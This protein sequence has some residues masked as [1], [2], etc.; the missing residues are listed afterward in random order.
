MTDK[1]LLPCPFCGGGETII[2]ENKGVWGGANSSSEPISVEVKHWCEEFEGMKSRLLSFV[3][4][5]R[6]T[7]IARWNKRELK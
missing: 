2:H 5:D 4:K 3:G 7:A 1:E 6:T